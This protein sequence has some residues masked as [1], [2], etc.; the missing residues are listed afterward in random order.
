MKEG[1]RAISGIVEELYMRKSEPPPLK[2]VC[3]RGSEAY[4]TLRVNSSARLPW[5]VAGICMKS[6]T[7]DLSRSWRASFRSSKQE[8]FPRECLVIIFARLK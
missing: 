1:R 8:F 7:C 3:E 2:E 6:S 4:E 5:I